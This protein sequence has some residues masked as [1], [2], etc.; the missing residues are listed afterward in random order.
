M[1]TYIFDAIKIDAQLQAMKPPQRL[2]FGIFLFE[3]AL[4]WF[5][6]WQS[7]TN[8]GGGGDLRAALASCWARL[9]DTTG[10]SKPFV[11]VE[12][13]ERWLPETEGSASLYT[14]PAIDAVDIACNLVEY[15]GSGDV[16][17]LIASATSRRDTIDLYIQNTTSLNSNAPSFETD[18][19]SHP[20]MQAEFKLM[21]EEISLLESPETEIVGTLTVALKHVASETFRASHWPASS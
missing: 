10:T 8:T 20:L 4:P 17:L 12:D 3:R 18:I 21:Y 15:L 11:A 1:T 9:E 5:L 19:L 7:D 14:S 16:G 13:C 2:A 6:K